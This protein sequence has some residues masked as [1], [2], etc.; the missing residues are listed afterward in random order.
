LKAR[1]FGRVISRPVVPVV[2][3]HVGQGRRWVPAMSGQ[4]TIKYLQ[5][6]MERESCGWPWPAV[7]LAPHNRIDSCGLSS[8][9]P[10]QSFS[11]WIHG[12]GG[13]WLNL[14]PSN[15]RKHLCLSN[16]CCFFL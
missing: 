15:F 14:C 13:L 12:S 3:Y 5:V 2:A 4:V 7:Q 16:V 6:T 9:S 8:F 11:S 1:G 10:P